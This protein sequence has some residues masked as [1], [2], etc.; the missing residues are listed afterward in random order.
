MRT[1]RFLYF[2]LLLALVLPPATTLALA[3]EAGTFSINNQSIQ[4][5]GILYFPVFE[6]RTHCSNTTS[7][8]LIW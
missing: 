3:P 8:N 2:A 1:Q 6:P 7:S 4:F 5:N